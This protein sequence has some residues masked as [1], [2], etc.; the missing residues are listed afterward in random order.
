M[1]REWIG[2]RSSGD[3]QRRAAGFEWVQLNWHDSADR[4]WLREESGL[5]AVTIAS[6]L[7]PYTRARAFTNEEGHWVTTL[8][9]I[10]PTDAE[11]ELVS[12]RVYAAAARIITITR[13]PVPA[14]ASLLERCRRAGE[15][16]FSNSRFLILLCELLEEQ[17]TDALVELEEA[18]DELED[19]IENDGREPRD[20]LRHLRQ[21]L[22]RLRR[23]LQPQRD[24]V[25]Q[26]GRLSQEAPLEASQSRRK[27]HEGQWR[28][29]LN[30]FVRNVESLHELSERL[31]IL[32]DYLRV[33]SEQQINRTMYMLTL[34][35]TFFLPFT[36][37]ASLLG[38]NVPG[39]PG[40]DHPWGFWLVCGFILLLAAGQGLLIR[41]WRLLN[42][43]GVL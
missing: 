14:L 27:R 29:I 19:C 42:R 30:A 6:L 22:S 37:I 23:H 7:E 18:V 25:Q 3:S 33:R 31:Q 13:A 9:A 24:A 38:M 10:V 1:E 17:F 39:I 12:I 41:H 2:A 43:K 36:F 11:A 34:A 20:E 5:D 26:L 8:R 16:S 21:R 28:E 35:T 40:A 4:A 15:R 32:H